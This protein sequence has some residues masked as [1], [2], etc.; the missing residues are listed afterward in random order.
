MEFIT[1]KLIMVNFMLCEFCHNEKYTKKRRAMR[2][3]SLKPT[4]NKKS[5]QSGKKFR[6]IE[7]RKD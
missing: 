6:H 1:L 2:T 3:G 7:R 5:F 4:N